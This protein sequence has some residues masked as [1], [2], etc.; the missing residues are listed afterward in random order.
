MQARLKGITARHNMEECPPEVANLI[1]H[2]VQERLKTLVEKLASI[3]QHRIDIN[4]KVNKTLATSESVTVMLC[5][6]L[7]APYVSCAALRLL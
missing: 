5:V 6:K 4:V 1:S 2:A 3:A 7:F